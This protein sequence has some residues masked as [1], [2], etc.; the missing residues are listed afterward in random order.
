MVVGTVI[1]M[2]KGSKGAGDQMRQS[3]PDLLFH[4]QRSLAYG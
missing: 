1:L 3:A 2:L 4:C